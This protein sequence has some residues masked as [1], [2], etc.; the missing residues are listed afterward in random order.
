MGASTSIFMASGYSWSIMLS[1][2]MR[3]PCTQAA[4]KQ[5]A[6]ARFVRDGAG[7]SK[8]GQAK[9]WGSERTRPKW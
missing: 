1:S 5:H 9:Q 6:A 4:R 7:K 3:Q 2:S 8:G